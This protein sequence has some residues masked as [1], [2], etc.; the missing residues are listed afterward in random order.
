[1]IRQRGLAAITA[2]L[3]V[4][5]A[6]SAATLMLAQQSAMLDQTAMVAA[7]AQAD[8]YGQAGLD[9]ARG[10]MAQDPAHVDSLGEGWAQPMAG[11]PVERAVVSGFIVDE[12]GKLNLNNLVAN[13]KPSEPD[14]AA[15]RLLLANVGLA[16][17]LAEAVLDWIDPDGDLAGNGGA[18]DA[19]YLALPRPHRAA[20]LPMQQVEELYRVRGFDAKAV[21]RIRPYVTALPGPRTTVNFNTA[22][23]PVLAAFLPKVPREKLAAL[24]AARV[25]APLQSK[26]AIGAATGPE[27]DLASIQQSLDVKSAFFQASVTVSQDDVQVAGDALLERKAN[28]VTVVWRRPRF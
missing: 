26:N 15:F 12:Q 19:Y 9:W 7:R 6:A 17:E 28:A 23:E 16:P 13:G 27:G 18:E 11:L 21:A 2:L 5:V 1:M 14:L 22:P 3:I 24:A 25:K 20:N 10:V 8:A 4:A